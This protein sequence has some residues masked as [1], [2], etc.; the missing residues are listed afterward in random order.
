MVPTLVVGQHPSEETQAVEEP[1]HA[2]L[3]VL[4]H[5][6]LRHG[7]VTVSGIDSGSGSC[8]TIS[9]PGLSL[10]RPKYTSVSCQCSYKKLQTPKI[11]KINN[12]ITVCVQGFC[13][14][15]L[16]L[17]FQPNAPNAQFIQSLPTRYCSYN[18]TVL[19]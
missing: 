14:D 19:K 15:L 18:S 10:P 7:S 16:N 13:C 2:H 11:Q 6:F 17:V 1:L 9:S 4:L 3:S 8:V 5:C 12:V